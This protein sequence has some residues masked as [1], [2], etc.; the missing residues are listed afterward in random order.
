LRA[1]DA[2]GQRHLPEKTPR[3]FVFHDRDRSSRKG[4][5]R[6]RF[7]QTK[8]QSMI[9]RDQP[10][11]AT[12]HQN[13]AASQRMSINRG[14]QRARQ[15]KKYPRHTRDSEHHAMTLLAAI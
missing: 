11:I 2:A 4:N 14:N 10:I 13:K 9:V 5:S 12:Q 15:R 1:Y 7:R 3:H 6:A 8:A